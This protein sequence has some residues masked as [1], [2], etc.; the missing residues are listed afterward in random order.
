MN[1][2]VIII[3][4]FMLVSMPVLAI[5]GQARVEKNIILSEY[6]DVDSKPFPLRSRFRKDYEAS[7]YSIKNNFEHPLNIISAD[8]KNGVDGHIAFY[9]NKESS[10]VALSS[11][12][13]IAILTCIPTVGITLIVAAVATP[14]VMI[15]DYVSNRRMKKESILFSNDIDRIIL[16]QGDS[17]DFMTLSRVGK[18][19]LIQIT[20]R[21]ME[22][23]EIY[24][25]SKN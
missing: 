24:S 25:I 13:G 11:M 1:K 15:E 12:W 7:Q 9:E 21:D 18:K 20:F 2:V 6:V 14:F 22:T 10:G 16:N 4:C 5:E 3:I 8:I 17:V 23:G 19:P